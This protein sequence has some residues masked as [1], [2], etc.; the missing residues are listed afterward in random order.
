MVSRPKQQN[1]SFQTVAGRVQRRKEEPP[2]GAASK[3]DH[4]AGVMRILTSA[5]INLSLGNGLYVQL[6][7]GRKLNSDSS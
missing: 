6:K 7:T 5:A 2:M 3:L 4:S 1:P